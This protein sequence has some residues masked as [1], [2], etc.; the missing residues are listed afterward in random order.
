[1]YCGK[2]ND[3]KKILNQNDGKIT[4]LEN[5]AKSLST[6]YIEK[7]DADSR[8]HIALVITYGFVIFLAIILIGAPCYNATIGSQTP[9]DIDGLL[10]VFGSLYGTT[11][12]FV[13]GYFF[14][15]HNN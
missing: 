15:G 12:G 4:R 11:F 5:N 1:M 2:E 6:E 9:L 13:L 3:V 14:K 10:K 7:K 8:S